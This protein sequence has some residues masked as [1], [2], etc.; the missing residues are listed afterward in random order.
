MYGPF[1]EKIYRNTTVCRST[2]LFYI[3]NVSPS[4]A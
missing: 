1:D 2:P 3:P 4:I